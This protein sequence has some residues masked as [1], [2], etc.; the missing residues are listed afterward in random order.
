MGKFIEKVNQGKKLI[1]AVELP[2]KAFL[3]ALKV[4]E[5]CKV[6]LMDRAQ[7]QKLT[8][9]SPDVRLLTLSGE[10]GLITR[11]QLASNF[12]TVSGKPI[13][14]AF[15]R[16]KQTYTVVKKQN[17]VAAF[18]IFYIPK[19]CIANL[20]GKAIQG[21][22]YLICNEENGMPVRSTLR[23]VPGVAFK[24]M[25][26]V[27]EMYNIQN[28][29]QVGK[30]SRPDNR[31]A[32]AIGNLPDNATLNR[33]PRRMQNGAP[34]VSE[35]IQ[36]VNNN[37]VRQPQQVNRGVQGSQH[38]QQMQRPLRNQV[39]GAG[40]NMQHQQPRPQQPRP[41]QRPQQQMPQQQRPQQ[42]RPQQQRPVQNQ[43]MQRQQP[44]VHGGNA[45]VTQVKYKF[46]A[47][48][49]IV[50]MRS[51]K[52]VGFVFL[53]LNTGKEMKISMDKARECCSRRLVANIMLVQKPGTNI[54]FLRGN[55]ITLES[56]P[57]VIA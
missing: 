29:R 15:L 54:Q 33:K 28:I 42:P 53:D 43:N 5:I 36:A 57:E 4:R 18:R 3:R 46:K 17:N 10:S 14:I 38:V 21:G 13:K 6:S 49:R 31:T 50:D 20:N 7:R 11:Q 52:L 25:F 27:Q 39:Q 41:Q 30:F 1:N 8:P 2:D 24:K 48:K 51:R 47:I 56:L 26:K 16:S 40:Q 22:N 34:I 9:G 19:N 37:V 12:V 35:G 23:A 55:G 44:Q 45:P 32:N